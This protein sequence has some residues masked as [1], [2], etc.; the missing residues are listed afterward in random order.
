MLI[1]VALTILGGIQTPNAPTR[2]MAVNTAGTVGY[3]GAV[4]SADLAGMIRSKEVLTLVVPTDKAMSESADLRKKLGGDKPFILSLTID[5]AVDTSEIKSQP[6]LKKTR[7]GNSISFSGITSKLKIEAKGVLP[8]IR[9]VKS[10]V[11]CTN[12]IVYLVD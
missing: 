4:Y 2:M 1:S 8:G 9:S 5:G 3:M 10:I 11:K 12:G 7:S 6:L